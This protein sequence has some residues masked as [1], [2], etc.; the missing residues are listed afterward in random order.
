VE[1]KAQADLDRVTARGDR[2]ITNSRIEDLYGIIANQL[3]KKK[4][5]S[6]VYESDS[7]T[8]TE[9]GYCHS[10]DMS[11]LADDKSLLHQ[12]LSITNSNY[13]TT[14]LSTEDITVL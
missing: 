5:R 13:D 7:T 10:Q 14:G 6:K 8:G 2:A 1:T 4:K 12:P 9:L 3:K 11:V